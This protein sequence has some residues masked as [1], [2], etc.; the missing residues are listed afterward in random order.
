LAS[1]AIAPGSNPTLAADLLGD[2]ANAALW[3]AYVCNA[4]RV[5]NTFVH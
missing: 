1:E 4:K 3:I 5:A 2:V